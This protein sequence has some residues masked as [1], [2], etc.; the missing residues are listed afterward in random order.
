M[1]LLDIM[2]QKKQ[3][4]IAAESSAPVDNLSPRAAAQERTVSDRKVDPY[5]AVSH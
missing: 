1:G 3:E 4:E 2:E 5:E